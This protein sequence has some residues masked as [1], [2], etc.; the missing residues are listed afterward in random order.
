MSVSGNEAEKK[1]WKTPELVE[2]LL[3]FLDPPSILELAQAHP[4]TVG[5]LEGN[6]TWNRFIRR[7]CPFPPPNLQTTHYRFDEETE[8]KVVELRPIVGILQLMGSQQCHLLDLLDLICQRFPPIEIYTWGVPRDVEVTCTSHDVHYVSALGFV[9]L[10]LVEGAIGSLEQKIR[11]VCVIRIKG[12]LSSA[13]KSRMMRQAGMMEVDAYWFSCETQDESETLRTLVQCTERFTVRRL[14]ILGAIGEESLA[15]LAEALRSRKFQGLQL[16]EVDRNLMLEMRRNEL[17]AVWDALPEGS[18][19]HMNRTGRLF[20]A[21]TEE[22]WMSL[23]LCLDNED[24]IGAEN[25]E[26]EAENENP[27][28]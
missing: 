14:T 13:L 21:A 26:T 25:Y 20:N 7:S 27:E 15:A 1:F 5:I 28:N 10:E 8:Q 19:V 16:L 23:E 22:D 6:S 4:L 11:S 12:P 3:P 18:L 24:A 2:S 17:R 9:L